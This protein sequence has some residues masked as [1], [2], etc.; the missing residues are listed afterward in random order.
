MLRLCRA[1]GGCRSQSTRS[2]ERSVE[3]SWSQVPRVS[4]IRHASPIAECVAN[5]RH[6]SFAAT[7]LQPACGIVPR[8]DASAAWISSAPHGSSESRL[9][10]KALR[11]STESESLPC[12]CT[13]H[14]EPLLFRSFRFLLWRSPPAAVPE[15]NPRAGRVAHLHRHRRSLRWRRPP[16][17]SQ[18]AGPPCLPGRRPMP[19]PVRLPEHGRAPK[20][21]PAASRPAHLPR[22]ATTLL[23]APAP[24]AVQAPR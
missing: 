10:R 14:R 18:A 7:N 24:E 3:I 20:R 13:P 21:F 23:P 12:E 4:L 19:P 22:A 16:P 5:R 17:P 1:S 9:C 8:S 2:P 15:R 11:R 6:L